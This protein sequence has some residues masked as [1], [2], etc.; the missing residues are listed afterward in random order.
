VTPHYWTAAEMLLLQLDMLAYSDKSTEE[1]TVVI[2]AGIPVEWLNQA[3]NVQQ[4]TIPDGQVGWKWD[5]R[6]LHV[7][8][9]SHR[10][11][12]IRLGSAFPSDTPLQIDYLKR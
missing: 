4:L 6:R 10:R 5:G 7:E 11:I 3:M 1:P 9:K 12:H 2:S 8:I